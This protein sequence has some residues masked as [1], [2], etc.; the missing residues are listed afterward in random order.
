MIRVSAILYL[1]LKNSAFFEAFY[2]YASF[3]VSDNEPLGSNGRRHVRELYT[4]VKYET[5]EIVKQKNKI[6]ELDFAHRET[7]KDLVIG[8]IINDI[9]HE[10]QRGR[11]RESY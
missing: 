1:D 7:G 2:V 6:L 8:S 10:V 11:R 4:I 5:M 3:K 9:A